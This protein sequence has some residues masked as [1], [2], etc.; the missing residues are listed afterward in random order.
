M[1]PVIVELR[2]RLHLREAVGGNE[3]QWQGGQAVVA[4]EAENVFAI[5]GER[6]PHHVTFLRYPGDGEMAERHGPMPSQQRVYSEDC[7]RQDNE[8]KENGDSS[9][10]LVTSRSSNHRRTLRGTYP[11]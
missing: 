2:R 9:P 11:R 5:G 3:A 8:P 1:H 7:G 6:R 10:Y 4:Q